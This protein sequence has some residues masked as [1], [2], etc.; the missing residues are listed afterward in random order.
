M[1]CNRVLP[2]LTLLLRLPLSTTH[3]LLTLAVLMARLRY[4]QNLTVIFVVIFVIMIMIYGFTLEVPKGRLR[5]NHDFW[6]QDNDID[7]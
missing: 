6:D 4:N 2:P 1:L 7:D 3:P 5:Y